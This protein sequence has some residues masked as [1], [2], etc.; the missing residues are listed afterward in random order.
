MVSCWFPSIWSLQSAPS[1]ADHGQCPQHREHVHSHRSFG[2]LLVHKYGLGK[3]HGTY[4]DRDKKKKKKITRW[5]DNHKTI[6]GLMQVDW[7]FSKNYK[8]MLSFALSSRFCF[9]DMIPVKVNGVCF[10]IRRRIT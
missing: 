3:K 2:S 9:A 1:W 5:G 8:Y 6:R 4:K 7:I 10:N